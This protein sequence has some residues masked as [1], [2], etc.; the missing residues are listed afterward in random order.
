MAPG[1]A[2]EW[3]GERLFQAAKLVNEMQYQHFVFEEFARRLSPNVDAFAQYDITI[4]PNISAEFSQA[5]YR[6]GHSMLTDTVRSQDASGVFDDRTLVE[7]FLN[8]VLF[9]ELGAGALVK[10]ATQETM[11][12]I[13]EFVVDGLRNMLV[14]LPLDLAALNIARGRDVGLA[15]LNETRDYLFNETGEGTL[16]PYASWAQFGDNLLHPESYVN[17]IAA[18]ARGGE[19]LGDAIELPATLAIMPGHAQRPKQSSMPPR[20]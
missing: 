12:E 15:T 6:L 16:A 13:D 11:N 9:D 3:D 14:G 20:T 1:T 10:G 2:A 4:N 18:Y 17:F 5:V 8:P 7:S 19:P